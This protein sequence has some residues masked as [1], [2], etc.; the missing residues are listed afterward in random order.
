MLTLRQIRD[1]L[2]AHICEIQELSGRP[3]PTIIDGNFKP[4][5]GCE[6]F[7]SLN[8]CEVGVRLEPILGCEIKGNPF[9]DGY[10]ALTVAAIAKRLYELQ[11]NGA[12]NAKR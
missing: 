5:G 8:A 4:I 9:A 1:V 3:V 11:L 6:G 2:I 10:R 7:E 12:S